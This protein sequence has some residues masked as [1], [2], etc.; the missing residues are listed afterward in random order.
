MEGSLISL[1]GLLIFCVRLQL[2]WIGSLGV[3]DVSRR[4]WTL[5]DVASDNN[6]NNGTSDGAGTAESQLGHDNDPLGEIDQ[7]VQLLVAQFKQKMIWNQ[8]KINIKHVSYDELQH[9]GRWKLNI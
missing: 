3:R 5:Q 1:P 7:K 8:I 2:G 6:R 9:L 4:A